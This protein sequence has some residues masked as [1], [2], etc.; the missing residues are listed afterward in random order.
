MAGFLEKKA[1]QEMMKRAI[2][3]AWV[4]CTCIGMVIGPLVIAFENINI[5]RTD[6]N[7]TIDIWMDHWQRDVQ[8]LS[9]R[10]VNPRN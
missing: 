8:H 1:Q 2:D 5:T 10:G 6:L 3:A 9:D 7:N 4:G